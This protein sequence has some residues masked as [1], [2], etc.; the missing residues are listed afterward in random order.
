LPDRVFFTINSDNSVEFGAGL[1]KNL[2]IF[3]FV[4]T[5]ITVL[6]VFV[7]LAQLVSFKV[8]LFLPQMHT[9][10]TL[11][12][13]DYNLQKWLLVISRYYCISINTLLY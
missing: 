11:D 5:V 9:S 8:P 6:H 1:L 13:I 2:E 7:C 4:F 3:S 10:L 12:M